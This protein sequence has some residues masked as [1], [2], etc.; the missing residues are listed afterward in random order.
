MIAPVSRTYFAFVCT[1]GQEYT[2]RTMT[3]NTL[4]AGAARVDI[5]PAKPLQLSGYPH[6]RRISEGVHDPLWASA[7]YLE[8]GGAAVALIALDLIFLDSPTARACRRGVAAALRLP[9]AGVCISCTHTHSGPNMVRRPPGMGGGGGPLTDPDDAYV[10]SVAERIR[11][12][13][14]A[15]QAAAVP[16]ALAWTRA[17]IRGVGTNRH[18]PDWTTDP[19][20]GV[21]AVRARAD[22]A[23]LGLATFYGMH[24]TVLHE[25]SRLVSSDF[26]HYAREHL[27][28]AFGERTVVC[29]HNAPCGNQSPRHVVRGQTFAEA[30]RLGNLF[31][32]AVAGA[33]RALRPADTTAAPV[34]AAAL[35]AVDL[36]RR[37]IPPP[38][39]AEA[40]LA[41][42]RRQY[43]EGR[44]RGAPRADVRTAE[45]AVF[46]AERLVALA[47]AKA[48]GSLD[49]LLDSCLPADVQ[50]LRIGDRFVTALP[51]ELFTEYALRIKAALPGA[52]PVAYANGMLHGY[53]VTPEAAAA[54]GYEAAGSVLAPEAGARLAD[55]AVA[56][57]IGLRDTET[58]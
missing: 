34:L 20:C 48:D 26:P 45:C 27:R 41:H 44:E 58:V 40:T 6:V 7:L 18:N 54:G 31:G 35:R 39:E 14:L 11:A 8:S 50:A 42:Y 56:T 10:A 3:T 13:A 9:E 21:L 22:D 15:A 30:E 49:A 52:I 5:T 33:V 2:A 28:A 19:A 17:E 47:R 46:G 43:S 16:A 24:P 23:L 36:P 25:D 55:A 12:A 1:E 57:A 32:A 38:A 29:Y 53:V 37:A 4:R 51:G